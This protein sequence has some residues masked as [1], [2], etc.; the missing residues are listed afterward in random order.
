MLNPLPTYT[1]LLGQHASSSNN[2]SESIELSDRSRA[3]EYERIKTAIASRGT[4]FSLFVPI[5]GKVHGD[6]G[7]EIG[8]REG[9]RIQANLDMISSNEEQNRR[10]EEQGDFLPAS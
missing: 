3:A 1:I 2:R 4:R 5:R 9:R 6:R 7:S 10:Q 8:R